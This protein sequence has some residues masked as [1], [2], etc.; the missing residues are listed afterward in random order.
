MSFVY[1][2]FLFGLLALGIP[3]II[4]LFNFRRA[5]KVYFSSNQFL[6]NIKKA[7]STKLKIKHYLILLSRLLFI[8][9]L[10][11]T[12]AQPFIPA[13]EKNIQSNQA[14]IYLDNSFSMSN[15]VDEDLTALEAAISYVHHIIDIYPQNSLFLLLTN[16]FA[17]YSNTSKSRNEIEELITELNFSGI[18]RSIEEVFLRIKN[19]PLNESANDVFWLS[20][21][22]VS[23]SGDPSIVTKDTTYN[24]FLLP[25]V[26]SNS[27]NVYVDSLYLS[28]PFLMQSEK[29]KLNVVLRNDGNDYIED[30]LIKLFVNNIQ[31]ANGSLTINPYSTARIIFDLNTTLDKFNYG[32]ISF[33]DFPVTFDNDFYFSLTLSDRIS[34]IE[35]KETDSVTVIEKVFGNQGLFNFQSYNSSNIDYNDLSN[36]DLIILNELDNLDP[37]IQNVLENFLIQT[38][39]LLFI[40]SPDIDLLSFVS[41]TGF[42]EIIPDSIR[43]NQNIDHL[44]LA[45]P[46][47]TDIFEDNENQFNMPSARSVINIHGSAE[48]I[49]KYRDGRNYLSYKQPKNR[50]YLLTSPLSSDYTD[51]FSHAIFVPVMYR[52][53]MLSKKEF[54]RMY[55]ALDET[56]VK[57]SIDSI[58]SES[59]I[60]LKNQE[61]EIIP[62]AR[63]TGNEL[64]LDIPKFELDPSHYNI[65][66]QNVHKATI[67]FNPVKSESIL[68]QY[69]VENLR[70]ASR[71]NSYVKLFNTK[72]FDNFDK[73]IKEKY[74]GIPLWRITLILA[75]IFLLIEILL[76]RFL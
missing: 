68:E 34:I 57:I 28:N 40:P 71:E 16:D 63:V 21:F 58:S 22:Q 7:T 9:F 19:N 25:L 3:I 61:K 12:F 66:I 73:E 26:Y 72:G 2:Q 44:D 46:F 52:I 24:M 41:L 33:E 75:L 45:N 70:E 60:K 67:A 31:S 13:K 14:I 42:I 69:T 76:I 74:L 35:L 55:Y 20:D 29:N 37:T 53:A 59:I 6:L 62:E 56:N 17:P 36:A 30:L 47:F 64:M 38:G 8:F 32:S 15:Y 51:F 23:T 39:D 11:I 1:P 4:H 49:I 65:E 18:S 10:V 5:R 48:N 43:T 27:L 50:L 54:N